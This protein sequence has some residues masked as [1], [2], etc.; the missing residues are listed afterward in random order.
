L[1]LSHGIGVR[2][3]KLGFGLALPDVD[4]QVQSGQLTA[5]NH[6]EDTYLTPTPD[7]L[8]P[9]QTGSQYQDG[10]L[11]SFPTGKFSWK[12]LTPSQRDELKKFVLNK[13]ANI[14]ALAQSM[15]VV[16]PSL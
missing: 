16:A 2:P 1:E 12:D 8:V 11:I 7:D 4:I 6:P 15:D 14:R 3:K 13:T 5:E 10:I 9:S